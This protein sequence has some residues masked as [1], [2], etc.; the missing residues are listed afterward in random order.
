MPCPGL[1]LRSSRWLQALTLRTFCRRLRPR[2]D[3]FPWPC[4]T[5]TPTTQ[6]LG[7]GCG[8]SPGAGAGAGVDQGP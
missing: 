1:R 4:Q 7:G 3:S 6:S 2:H 8:V 5:D